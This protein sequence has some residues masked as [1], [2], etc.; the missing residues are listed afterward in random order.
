VNDVGHDEP[1]P[2]HPGIVVAR[3][4]AP[5]AAAAARSFSDLWAKGFDVRLVARGNLFRKY[6]TN[7][8]EPGSWR[9]GIVSY[10]EYV[11]GLWAAVLGTPYVELTKYE[12]DLWEFRDRLVRSA[13][14]CGGPRRHVVVAQGQELPNAFYELLRLVGVQATVLVDGEASVDGDGSTAKEI[15][16][17]LGAPL[18]TGSERSGLTTALHQFAA[19]LSQVGTRDL[20]LPPERSGPVPVLVGHE[21]LADEVAMIRETAASATR[22]KLGVLLPRAELVN[23]YRSVLSHTTSVPVRWYLST[24]GAP[25]GQQVDFSKPGITVATYASARGLLFDTVFMPAL[26][27]VNADSR[28]SGW[29]DSLLACA[30]TSKRRLVLSWHGT[31]TPT[32]VAALPRQVLDVRTAPLPPGTLDHPG[33]VTEH[34]AG[35]ESVTYTRPERVDSSSAALAARAL[36]RRDRDYP[37]SRRRVLLPDEEVGLAQ[38]MRRPEGSLR[39]ELPKGFRSLA[40]PLGEPAAAFDAFVTHNVRL[41]HSVA[42]RHRGAGLDD[43]DLVQHGLFGL[44]RAV[45]K[46]DASFGTKFSTYAVNWIK[47]SIQRAVAN[48]GSVIRIPV[49]QHE[50]VHKVR[51]ARNRLVAEHGVATLEA[52]AAA[53]GL[54][55]ERVTE[56]LR[57]AQGVLSLDAPVS[58]DTEATYADLHFEGSAQDPDEVHDR[59][60]VSALVRLALAT[61]R[62]REETILRLRFGF[63]TDEGLTLQEIGDR[64]GVTRERVRQIEAK[65]KRNLAAELSRGGVRNEDHAPSPAST[66]SREAHLARLAELARIRRTNGDL[67]SGDSTGLASAVF[68][69][70]MDF[71]EIVRRLIDLALDGDARTVRI[72]VSPRGEHPWL[73]LVH[74]GTSQ[75]GGALRSWL[76]PPGPSGLPRNSDSSDIDQVIPALARTFDEIT[77]WENA[78][79]VSGRACTSLTQA[80]RTGSW[81][82]AEAKGP[83]P[84]WVHSAGTDPSTTVLLLRRPRPVNQMA[85]SAKTLQ[86]LRHEFG[87]SLSERLRGGRLALTLDD[88]PVRRRDPFLAHNPAS[89]D[90]GTEL[91]SVDGHSA[92]VTP[93]VLP[94]PA[95]LSASDRN[96]AGGVVEWSRSQGF[97]VLCAD[98]F[99]SCGGWLE[100]DG[101]QSLPG[102]ALARVVV[103][104]ERSELAAWG[105]GRPGAVPTVPEPLRARLTALATIARR[106][107]EKVTALRPIEPLLLESAD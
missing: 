62:P 61:L 58:D 4:G 55:T 81:W 57:L 39:E 84:T 11:R 50:T 106:R 74:D 40:D 86:T 49:H 71:T 19:S 46:F 65:A 63:E 1:G 56:C 42:L 66:A 7:F 94:H 96:S 95:A 8:L 14:P 48:E 67:A 5:H 105:L 92:K 12:P 90:L 37:R 64:L 51:V 27:F 85:E 70:P 98:R 24:A 44:M 29:Y 35:A 89:Q 75:F 80:R 3:L 78:D 101:M 82:L 54:S 25:Q 73:A 88:V 18:T 17:I 34:A 59:A 36:L 22:E 104:I 93:R 33:P 15:A 31:G 52:L 103:E 9:A 16:R 60:D 13:P 87:L 47:Q 53:C 38:L 100:L 83:P 79:S 26:N 97:Y 91:V 68:G 45:E 10:R 76:C 21:T 107:S 28:T 2:P 6:V 69:D 77:V 30:V 23:T 99:V 41:V 102:T 43:E 20:P 32:L 72:S